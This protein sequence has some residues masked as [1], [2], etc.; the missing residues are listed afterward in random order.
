MKKKLTMILAVCML[1]T[2]FATGIVSAF[3][4]EK[5]AGTGAFSKEKDRIK[6]IWLF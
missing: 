1:C 4:E 2:L 6:I 3:A 5:E